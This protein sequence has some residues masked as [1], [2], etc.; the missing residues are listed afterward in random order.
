MR[1]SDSSR[2]NLGRDLQNEPDGFGMGASRPQDTEPKQQ[3]NDLIHKESDRPEELL[4]FTLFPITNAAAEGFNSKIQS[5]KADAR[6]FRNALN[7]RTRILF[8]CGRLD[9]FPSTHEIP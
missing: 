2:S 4:N 7:Y 6:G 8:Y 3:K 1:P 9:L 5:L